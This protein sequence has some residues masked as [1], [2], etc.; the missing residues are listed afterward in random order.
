MNH[1]DGHKRAARAGFAALACAVMVSACTSTE[2]TLDPA[3]LTAEPATA[4]STP[5][6]VSTPATGQAPATT[7]PP[8]P[9]QQQI[10]ALSP[11]ITRV[12]FMGLIGVPE[13]AV[14]QF[15][16]RF[17]QQSAAHRFA[18]VPST[19]PSAAYRLKGFASTSPEGGKT[20]V[21]YVWDIADAN[22]ARIN[23]F[24]GQH[25][26]VGQGEGWQAV[27]ETDLQAIADKSASDFAA[28]LTNRTQ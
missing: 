3:A 27:T 6:P 10:A 19:D 12:Q 2:A 25:T 28:W 5:P 14:N 16:S 9:G 11:S 17:T 7:T 8:A 15:S 20:V 23:R 24:S 26:A 22:G 4:V 13:A 21:F 18:V 1:S